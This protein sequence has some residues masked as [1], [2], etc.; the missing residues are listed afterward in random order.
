MTT[1]SRERSSAP[2]GT[3]SAHPSS[4][5]SGAAA[6]T[7]ETAHPETGAAGAGQPSEPAAPPPGPDGPRANRALIAGLAALAVGASLLA[8]RDWRP[9]AQPTGALDQR[10]ATG[11]WGLC[12]R[13]VTERLPS[14]PPVQFPWFDERAI[15]R[16]TDS[17]VVV[18]ASVDAS[19][20]AG[21]RV[22]VPFVCRAR[23]LGADRWLE[24]STVVQAP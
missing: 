6:R 17:V 4:R 15:Q 16:V 19:S 14:T 3:E 12:K 21:A 11:A 22:R 9:P 24:E 10:L 18:R 5:P 20:S 2:A 7:D 1:P 13:I 8:T 23:W